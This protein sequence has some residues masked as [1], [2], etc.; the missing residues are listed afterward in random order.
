MSLVCWGEIK[1][2]MHALYRY[3]KFS[4]YL[5]VHSNNETSARIEGGGYP[6]ANTN[7]SYQSLHS[8]RKHCLQK[9]LLHTRA[10]TV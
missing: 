6:N 3:S 9:K 5:H 8:F 7:N 1:W 2:K 10:L 4:W